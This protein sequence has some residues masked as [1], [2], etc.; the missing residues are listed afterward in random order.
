LRHSTIKL[1]SATY[2]HLVGGAGKKAAEASAALVF[3]IAPTGLI[4]IIDGPQGR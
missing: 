2:S 1:T 4:K 3:G